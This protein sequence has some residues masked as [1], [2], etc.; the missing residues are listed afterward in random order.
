MKVRVTIISFAAMLVLLLGATEHLFANESSEATKSKDKANP[1]QQSQ[2]TQEAAD[3]AAQSSKEA[4]SSNQQLNFQVQGTEAQ[5]A[6]NVAEEANPL[7]EEE[8]IIELDDYVVTGTRTKKA[9]MDVPV[10]T[11]LI[12]QAD[13]DPIKPRTLADAMEFATGVRVESNCQNCNFSQI[14]LLGL[15]GPYTQILVDGQ[16]IMSSLAQVY[17]IEHIPAS[18][19]DRIEVV[20]GGG[21]ALYGPG[22]VAGVIN[23]IPREPERNGGSIEGRYE[24]M[25]GD[26]SNYSVRGNMDY[27]S[28][29][30]KTNMTFYGQIDEM[31]GWDENGDRF[32]D[33]A[34]RELDSFGFRV[35][36]YFL[37]DE[38]KFTL[39]YNR[40][41]EHRRGGNKLNQPDF[42]ADISEAV[43][44]I[45]DSLSLTWSHKISDDFDYRFTASYVQTDRDSYYGAGMDPN[46]YGVTDNPLY[47]LDSQFNHYFDEH[48]VTW[49]AQYQRDELEDKQPA[50]N[51]ILDEEYSN[52]GFYLQD[53]W[54]LNEEWEL[55]LGGRVDKSSELDDAIASPRLALC[56]SPTEV[57]NVRSSVAWGF[58][59]PQVFDEDLHITQS[60][61]EGQVIRNANNL[62][63]ESSISYMLGS[64]YTPPV[65]DGQLQLEG[66]IFYTDIDDT[67]FV[68]ETDDPATT[69]QTEFTRINRGGA[70]VYGAEMNVG[71]K[72]TDRFRAEVG[73]V[74]QRSEYVDRETDFNTK[75]FWRTPNR[76]GALKFYWEDPE[77]V[78]LFLG[79][80][81]TGTMK[82][83]HYAGFIANDRMEN[84]DSFVAWDASVSKRFKLGSSKSDNL[85]LTAGV[86]N[87][88]NEYQD[89]LDQGVDR[90]AGYT[91][92]PRF[93][94][95]FFVSLEYLF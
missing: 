34:E 56:W 63:E 82:V 69:N 23:I 24:S 95:T 5:A 42:M 58:R 48:T 6:S 46:A 85:K 10:R 92:G 2:E 66:N 87:F 13:I 70:T 43:D 35:N 27:V 90:D 29:D 8:E 54:A 3:R 41:K 89:D 55:I 86:R 91:Y 31:D 73:F 32:T 64:E 68:D 30:K 93:P 88:T 39:D 38:G 40:T 15:E 78:N 72:F 83:P 11:E 16:P 61:G 81:Y 50:Y 26:T 77:V 14:R 37:D 52:T 28:P 59:A 18:M 22:A 19:I 75:E 51:R 84:S 12:K 65:G 60:G 44:T 94:R 20:K 76:Y 45:R 7:A 1:E 36:R 21:S 4:E 53:D 47:I 67:F 57:L 74:E 17:G 62:D 25:D 9:L 79:A 80:K 49:G 71:Y 33:S